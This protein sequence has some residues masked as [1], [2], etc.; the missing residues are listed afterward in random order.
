MG[1][2]PPYSRTSPAFNIVGIKKLVCNT[3]SSVIIIA[4]TNSAGNANI[5]STVAVKI[6]QTVKGI[7]IKVIPLVLA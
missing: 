6:P 7:L 2:P 5:A 1:L 3:L 4:L